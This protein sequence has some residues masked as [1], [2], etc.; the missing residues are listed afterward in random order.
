MLTLSR[1][2]PTSRRGTGGD[3][4]V[5]VVVEELGTWRGEREPSRRLGVYYT[6]LGG[7]VRED[8]SG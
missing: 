7:E 3:D 8:L 4:V 2:K 1:T 6:C 5:G